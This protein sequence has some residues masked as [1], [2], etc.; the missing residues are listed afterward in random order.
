LSSFQNPSE[1]RL[2]PFKTPEEACEE[3][4]RI[5]FNHRTDI[6]VGMKDPKPESYSQKV[7]KRK[8]HNW[9]MSEFGHC[10]HCSLGLRIIE[11]DEKVEIL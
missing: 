1:S 9:Y 3:H 11:N 10:I 8:V 7:H 2:I 5:Y 4:D 6:I